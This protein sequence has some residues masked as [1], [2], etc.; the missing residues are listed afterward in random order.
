MIALPAEHKN[1]HKWK[2]QEEMEK[3]CHNTCPKNNIKSVII[4]HKKKNK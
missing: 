4:V 3:L 2:I 1:L